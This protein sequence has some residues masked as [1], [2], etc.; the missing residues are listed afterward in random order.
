MK[1]NI[2]SVIVIV[3]MSYGQLA[4]AALVGND[5]I[6]RSTLDGGFLNFVDTGSIFTD[7][8]VIDEWTIYGK[9]AGDLY[10]QVYRGSLTSAS[11][12][13][14]GQ[15]HV[16]VLGNG[17]ETFTIDA[18]DQISVQ[19]GD[20]MGWAFDIPATVPFDYIGDKIRWGSFSNTIG[21]FVNFHTAST[22]T[23]SIAANLNTGN[24]S[25]VPIPAAVWLFGSGLMGLIGM[26]RKKSKSV[27]VSA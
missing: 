14:I 5:P 25:P 17:V 24:P 7:S 15:N 9:R 12:Q 3:L 26:M 20:V 2:F 10:L 18:V 11:L 16:S 13:L 27:T 19:A 22:R 4:Q 23:Y 21:E 6:D 8:G 1:K